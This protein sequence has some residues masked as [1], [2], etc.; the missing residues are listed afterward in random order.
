MKTVHFVE[1]RRD[2]KAPVLSK[3]TQPAVCHHRTV[4]TNCTYRLA[5]IA[6]IALFA[7]LAPTEFRLKGLTDPKEP[8]AGPRRGSPDNLSVVGAQQSKRGVQPDTESDC[9]HEVTQL[10]V[11]DSRVDIARVDEPDAAQPLVDRHARLLVQHEHRFAAGGVAEEIARA[12]TVFSHPAD[13]SR[14]ARKEALRRDQF[15]TAKRPFQTQS[16]G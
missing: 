4:R 11:P 15:L 12:E 10:E 7:P 13:G 5:P 16:R 14:S 1:T 3:G 6:P 2:S 9:T 8:F